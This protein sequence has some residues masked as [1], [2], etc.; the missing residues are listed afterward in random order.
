MRY[1]SGK[2][3][4]I[5]WLGFARVN[6]VSPGFIK[7]SIS[8]SIAEDIMSAIMDKVPMGYVIHPTI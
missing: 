2:S 4:A 5:E 6:R 3:L 8:G 1:Y 7:T